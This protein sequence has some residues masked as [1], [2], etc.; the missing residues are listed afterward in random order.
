MKRSRSQIM[1]DIQNSEKSLENQFNLAIHNHY[2]IIS[3]TVELDNV[4]LQNH[5]NDT[6]IQYS[7]WRDEFLNV[8]QE[9]QEGQY[10]EILKSL[11]DNCRTEWQTKCHTDEENED[12]NLKFY[13][14]RLKVCLNHQLWLNF[15]I[16]VTSDDDFQIEKMRI[17]TLYNDINMLTTYSSEEYNTLSEELQLPTDV[18]YDLIGFFYFIF[19]FDP[20]CPSEVYE[21]QDN[22]IPNITRE[23]V[24]TFGFTRCRDLVNFSERHYCKTKNTQKRLKAIE[25]VKTVFLPLYGSDYEEVD[26]DKDQ[27]E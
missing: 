19:M 3:D 21:L 4:D 13:S 20:E 11:I 27:K 18:L 22:S 23:I 9:Y 2:K 24:E 25:T 17:S 14:N 26:Q 7:R 10:Y 1:L 16:F 5:Q 8:Y 15:E 6:L 12:S